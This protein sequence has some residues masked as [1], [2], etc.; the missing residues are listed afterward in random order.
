MWPQELVNQN[1]AI[2]L[3]WEACTT[4]PLVRGFGWSKERKRVRRVCVGEGEGEGEC[5]CGGV[6]VSSG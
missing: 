1:N 2:I 5:V 6:V 3:T 4:T